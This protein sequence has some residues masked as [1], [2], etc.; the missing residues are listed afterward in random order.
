MKNT[1]IQL[2]FQLRVFA[3]DKGTPQKSAFIDVTVIINRL[4]GT[5]QFSS[6]NYERTI[7]ESLAVDSTV[8]QTRASPG[9]SYSFFF[10]IS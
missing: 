8:L 9:V 5:L 3:R 2:L 6:Q 10:T 4:E 1:T 7:D